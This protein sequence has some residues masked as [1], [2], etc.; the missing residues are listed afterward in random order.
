MPCVSDYG[1]DPAELRRSQEAV[2]KR[3]K[4][5]RLIKA[6]LCGILTVLEVPGDQGKI[7]ELVDWKEAGVKRSDAEAWWT[8][9]KKEDDLRRMKEASAARKK[10]IKKN[11]L[12]KLTPEEKEVLGL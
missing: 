7:F 2:A 1:P 4:E 6:T 12:S 3:E 5:E 11:A 8:K 9:H 10:E